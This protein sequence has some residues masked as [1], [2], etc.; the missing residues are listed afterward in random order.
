MFPCPNTQR[1]CREKVPTLSSFLQFQRWIFMKYS[2]FKTKKEI[3]MQ[4]VIKV[5][6]WLILPIYPYVTLESYLLSSVYIQAI[7][8]LRDTSTSVNICH[9]LQRSMYP[10]FNISE[11]S[12]CAY[13]LVFKSTLWA[14]RIYCVGKIGGKNFFNGVVY[15]RIYKAI[16][17]MMALW[18]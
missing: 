13:N 17:S 5:N 12:W 16:L 1:K 11:F 6:K 8:S 14:L 18:N 10:I 7:K 2:I 9:H 15:F 3:W 4:A